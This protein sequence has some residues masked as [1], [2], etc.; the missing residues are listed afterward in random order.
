MDT[1]WAKTDADYVS[2]NSAQDGEVVQELYD[3]G[4]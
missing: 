3:P 1:L 2:W 4:N